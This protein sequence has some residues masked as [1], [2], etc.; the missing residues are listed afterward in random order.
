MTARLVRNGS[1]QLWY[2]FHT[3]YCSQVPIMNEAQIFLKNSRWMQ[4][5]CL[6]LSHDI[7][8]LNKSLFVHLD[9]LTRKYKRLLLFTRRTWWLYG[10]SCSF[11]KTLFLIVWDENWQ[12]HHPQVVAPISSSTDKWNAGAT[13]SSSI[14]Y[15]I[16]IVLSGSIQQMMKQIIPQHYVCVLYLS[17]L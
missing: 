7:W 4:I 3:I 16:D 13:P 5:I 10:F 6:H 17:R 1:L 2:L 9:L 15:C 12:W 11:E 8:L 14:S